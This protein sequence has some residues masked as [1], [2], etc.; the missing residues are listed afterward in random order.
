[1][2]AEA[3]AQDLF[4]HLSTT[5]RLTPHPLKMMSLTSAQGNRE[6]IKEATKVEYELSYEFSNPLYA[7][8]AS[9]KFDKVAHKIMKGFEKRCHEVYPVHQHKHKGQ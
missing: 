1:M 4:H 8:A 5:W 7:M 2:Q 6:T 3:E 9:S